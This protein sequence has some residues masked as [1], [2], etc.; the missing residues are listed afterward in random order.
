MHVYTIFNY[1]ICY[2]AGCLIL[3]SPLPFVHGLSVQGRLARGLG[4]RTLQVDGGVQWPRGVEE[5][6][7]QQAPRHGTAMCIWLVVIGD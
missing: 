4:Q 1:R 6:Q 7:V 3:Y 5:H 2:V